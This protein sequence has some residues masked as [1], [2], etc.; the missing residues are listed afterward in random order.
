LYQLHLAGG[1]FEFTTLAVID[2]DTI[3]SYKSNY[4]TITT[5]PIYNCM[6]SH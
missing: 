6:T 4:H 1:W 3:G 2:T 5:T